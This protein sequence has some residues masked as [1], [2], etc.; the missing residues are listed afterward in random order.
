MS[1]GVLISIVI[2]SHNNRER[3][4][5][6]LESACRLEC[7]LSTLEVVVQDDNSTD[8]TLEAFSGRHYP[9][10]LDIARGEHGNQ[11][12]AT[13]A[14][15]R[16]ASGK[17]ILCSAS[18]LVFDS[19]LVA[20]HLAA[21]ERFAG[22]DVAVLGH[23]PYP[24]ELNERPFMFYLMHGGPQFGYA[25]IRD[26]CRLVPN[27][28]YAPNLSL[29]REV[30]DRVGGFDPFF[31]YGGQDT[32]LGYRLAFAGVRLC[33]EPAAIAWHHHPVC[34]QDY[35]RRQ[36]AA[37]IAS[38]LLEARYPELEGGP[39]LW[40]AAISAYLAY[41][42]AMIDRDLQVVEIL[43]PILA[44][45]HPDYQK[46]WSSVVYPQG[47]ESRRLDR[48]A[49]KLL[50]ATKTLFAAYD[51]LTRYHWGQS[52]IEE[53][54]RRHGTERVASL[55]NGRFLKFQSTLQVRRVAQRKL[56]AHGIELRLCHPRDELD[57]LILLCTQGY[58]EILAALG[59]VCDVSEG[60]CNRQVSVVVDQ[61]RLTG[62]Q[63]DKL[64]EVVDVIPCARSEEGLLRALGQ[65]RG[66]TVVVREAA[67]FTEQREAREIAQSM[68]RRVAKL[69]VIGSGAQH[70]TLEQRVIG[71]RLDGT[72]LTLPPSAGVPEDGGSQVIDV[73]VAGAVRI[74]GSL[75][76]ELSAAGASLAGAG[77]RDWTFA[78]GRIVADRGE[79]ACYV[80]ALDEAAL[81]G[82]GETRPVAAQTVG[83]A[84][85]GP[86]R[87]ATG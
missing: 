60:V 28:C 39:G 46:L 22:E 78:L 6:T 63:I 32:D 79:V 20:S 23:L 42:R 18:D 66:E 80:P 8:G 44:G 24:P 13:N 10:R 65:T 49:Q 86:G 75:A 76:R 11:S 52:V 5:Q 47:Q 21:H 67:P 29:K 33:Y 74:R 81:R 72:V 83:S 48:S 45:A 15:I 62:E 64:N 40:D 35:F 85:V 14:A 9:F 34:L 84:T 38:V 68:F 70:P 16:R 19:R 2:P 37:G 58:T 7:D 31:R 69:A 82:H 53:A 27:F 54:I 4:E 1:D 59:P 77:G 43:E 12:A 25:A 55:V 30:M 36:Q 41:P 17:Y 73:P 71:Y 26:T 3:L 61:R 50:E 51:R 87:S 57:S 56:A